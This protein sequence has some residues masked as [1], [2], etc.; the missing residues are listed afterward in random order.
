MFAL[1]TH[2]TNPDKELADLLEDCHGTLGALIASDDGF[3]INHQLR[4]GLPKEKIAAIT[5]SLLGLAESVAYESEQGNCNNVIVENEK[6][7][8]LFLRITP[9]RVLTVM[10][11]T[12]VS[13]GMLLSA[14]RQVVNNLRKMGN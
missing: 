7:I 1:N 4:T 3:V 2:P 12:T 6:G 10:A 8:M 9:T 14:T 13:L 11:N 5:S